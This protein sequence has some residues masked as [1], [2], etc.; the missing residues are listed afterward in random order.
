MKSSIKWRGAKPAY[1]AT[2]TISTVAGLIV[3]TGAPMKWAMCAAP[4]N[5]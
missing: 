1:R 4:W 3:A 5:W 2:L